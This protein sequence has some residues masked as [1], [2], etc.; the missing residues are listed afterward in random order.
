MAKRGVC[1]DFLKGCKGEKGEGEKVDEGVSCG[2]VVVWSC[3]E[4]RG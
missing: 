4:R 3:G 2:R 1:L